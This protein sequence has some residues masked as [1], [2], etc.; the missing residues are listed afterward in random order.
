MPGEYHADLVVLLLD[1]KPVLAIVVEVQLGEDG[2]KRYTWPAYVA[3]VRAQYSC[4]CLLL[5]FCV[6]DE[7]AEWA[8]EPITIGAGFEMQPFVIG[9]QGVPVVR[10]PQAPVEL[11]VMSAMAH[12]KG[13]VDTAVAV[14]MAAMGAVKADDGELHALYYDLIEL[15]LSAKRRFAM[16]PHGYEYQS[17]SM[18]RSFN[19]GK[20]AN[21]AANVLDFLDAR[22][23][24]VS[25]TQKQRITECRDLDTLRAWVRKAATVAAAD[26]LFE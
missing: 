17:E 12:G 6:D 7:T 15:S 16:L 20:I 2:R 10:S 5:V 21:A 9:P 3:S 11:A 23:L 8:A 26:E 18:R 14:A 13:D 25:D 24:E 4:P 22:G 1:G 19:E